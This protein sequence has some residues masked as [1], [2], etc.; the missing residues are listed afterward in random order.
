VRQLNRVPSVI[1]ELPRP[2]GHEPHY[3]HQRQSSLERD[4]VQWD[5]AAAQRNEARRPDVESGVTD[6]QWADGEIRARLAY[7]ATAAGSLAGW[8]DARPRIIAT[9]QHEE[10]SR[11]AEQI[12]QQM[13]AG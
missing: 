1:V 8:E 3:R 12:R 2:T 10:A 6:S 7:F 11:L 9:W 5:V 4:Q 13:N